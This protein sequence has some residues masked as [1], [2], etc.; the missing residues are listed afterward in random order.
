MISCVEVRTMG[1]PIVDALLLSR[2]LGVMLVRGIIELMSTPH[3]SLVLTPDSF[4]FSLR[5]LF[6]SDVRR[7]IARRR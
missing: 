5:S 6:E 3:S 7:G 1:I 2:I 4:S